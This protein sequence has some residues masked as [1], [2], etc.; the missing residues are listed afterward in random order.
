MRKGQRV[1]ED[2]AGEDER[3]QGLSYEVNHERT[4]KSRCW[5]AAG[6]VVA[7]MSVVLVLS[8]GGVDAAAQETSTLL[9]LRPI[10]KAKNADPAKEMAPV[11]QADV[12]EIKIGGK[13]ATITA[14]TPLLNGPTTLQLVVLFDSQERIG[15]D[16]QFDAIKSMFNS[17]P[18]NVEI[19]VGSLLQG[20]AQ[21]RQPFTTDRTLAGNALH[22]PSMEDVLNPKNN[23]GNPYYCLHDLAAHWPDPDPK[24]VRAVLVFT[25][26]IFISGGN[27]YGLQAMEIAIEDLIRAGVAPFSIF[28]LDHGSMNA[29]VENAMI[30]S[31]QDE[32]DELARSTN[33]QALYIPHAL[34]TTA[35][36]VPL[37]HRFTSILKSE[38]VVTVTVKGAGLQRLD[39]KSANEGIKVAGPD[40]VVIGNGMSA[41]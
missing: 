19:A 5:R 12:S 15:A 13:A 14:W 31:G 40:E 35:G 25:D 32:L 6:V 7:A 37:L 17:L 8:A 21:I 22:M 27:G 33:G 4:L 41:K 34:T 23:N 9:V 10:A 26:G 20:K 18:G 38:A 3:M 1:S 2:E 11:A 30:M 39:I 28:Y 16:R 24:K 29:S 36:F